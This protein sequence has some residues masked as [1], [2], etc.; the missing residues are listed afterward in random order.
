MKRR[1]AA[2]LWLLA[3]CQSVLGIEEGRPLQDAGLE[4]ATDA[5]VDSALQDG[6]TAKCPNDCDDGDPCT[7]DVCSLAGCEHSV[8]PGASCS[9]G[10]VC[11]GAE[12]CDAQGVCQPGQP[13]A[14]DDGNSCTTDVCDPAN[15]VSHIP[16]QHSPAKICANTQAQ[17]PAGYFRSKTLICDPECGTNCPYCVNGFLCERACLATVQACCSDNCAT[18]CPGGYTKTSEFQTTTCGCATVAGPAVVC[19]RS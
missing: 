14:L 6:A 9:D 3:G 1:L 16:V 5:A 8:T 12:I 15:G 11:N 18:A 17:C 2:L 4:A 7:A 13:L 19:T 10:N